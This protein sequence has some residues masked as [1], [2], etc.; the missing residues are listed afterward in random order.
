M[1]KT[2][3]FT[4]V[5]FTLLAS[6]CFGEGLKTY[7]VK[8]LQVDRA[9]ALE[10]LAGPYRS[11]TPGSVDGA[12]QYRHTGINGNR[13]IVTENGAI[14][15]IQQTEPQK[16]DQAFLSNKMAEILETLEL[17]NA[18]FASSIR[19]EYADYTNLFRLKGKKLI[20]GLEVLRGDRIEMSAAKTGG[21]EISLEFYLKWY[22]VEKSEQTAPSTLT[23]GGEKVYFYEGGYY[24]PGVR[25]V[26]KSLTK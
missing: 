11:E 5:I 8:P 23:N 6:L 17:K 26:N 4:A 24:R 21:Q 19:W 12:R 10:N 25:Q 22:E 9:K 18:V 15:V 20:D 16:I 3:I 7:K 1:K 2:A 13:L 14:Q